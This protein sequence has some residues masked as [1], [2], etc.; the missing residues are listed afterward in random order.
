MQIP[1]ADGFCTPGRGG[2]RVASTTDP[3]GESW[4][5]A[6]AA[7]PHPR[8]LLGAVCCDQLMLPTQQRN[9]KGEVGG[10]TTTSRMRGSNFAPE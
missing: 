5:E 9:E 6:R 2:K 7:E 1:A 4:L 8:C 3:T 10:G